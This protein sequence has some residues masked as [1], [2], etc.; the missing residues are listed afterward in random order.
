MRFFKRAIQGI[1]IT[2]IISTGLLANVDD[3]R[4][5]FHVLAWDKSLRNAPIGYVTKGKFVPIPNLNDHSRTVR[6]FRYEGP[7]IIRFYNRNASQG[8]APLGSLSVPQGA[9]QLLLILIP[10]EAD[11]IRV[12]SIPNSEKNFPA[13][14]FRLINMT[15]AELAVLI[16]GKKLLIGPKEM[17]SGDLSAAEGLNFEVKIAAQTENNSARLVY[18]NRWNRGANRRYLCFIQEAPG[19]ANRKLRVKVVS[20]TPVAD[21]ARGDQAPGLPEPVILGPEDF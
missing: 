21:S 14:S 11:R 12:L 3:V 2:L 9:S 5:D 8:S 20:D 1:L 18:S 15:E 17:E 16:D 4:V 6:S 10:N 19:A 13:N 7:P